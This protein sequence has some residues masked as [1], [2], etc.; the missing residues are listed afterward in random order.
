[1]QDYSCNI[2]CGL[3]GINMWMR[4]CMQNFS[5]TR[6][7][8]HSV[9]VCVWG[10]EGRER[11][12]LVYLYYCTLLFVMQFCSLSVFGTMVDSNNNQSMAVLVSNTNFS[13]H[14]LVFLQPCSLLVSKPTL[15]YN[16]T[17]GLYLLRGNSCHASVR[18][19]AESYRISQ[20]RCRAVESVR[21]G[22]QC[23]LW[24]QP[25]RVR[26]VSRGISRFR[27]IMCLMVR[28]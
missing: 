1:M 20:V 6:G 22:A 4:E 7:I 21:S 15:H 18:S 27:C 19:D 13:Y 16:S 2:L 9:S 26:S 8:V 28:F 3:Y 11:E 10:G 14:M 25:G 23:E 5:C 24:N 12:R 17:C